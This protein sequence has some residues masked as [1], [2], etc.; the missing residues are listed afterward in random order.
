MYNQGLNQVGWLDKTK[1]AR[2]AFLPLK[3]RSREYEGENF[4]RKRGFSPEE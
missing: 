4:R 3:T 1:V 2:E